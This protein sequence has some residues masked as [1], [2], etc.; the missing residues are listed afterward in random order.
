MTLA[1]IAPLIKGSD[2]CVM[3]MDHLGYDSFL[4]SAARHTRVHVIE[5]VGARARG[6]GGVGRKR[7]TCR[8]GRGM[9]A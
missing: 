2:T 6:I 1:E 9:H 5:R 7:G 3:K 8:C 4:A